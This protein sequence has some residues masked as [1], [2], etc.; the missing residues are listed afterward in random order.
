MDYPNA[1]A[2]LNLCSGSWALKLPFLQEA[3]GP[4]LRAIYVVRDPRAWVYLML[5]NSR[6]SLYSLKNIP[7][8]LSLIFRQDG[9]S[10]RCPSAFAP[11]FGPLWQ[12]VSRS[13]NSAVLL[14]AHLWRAHTAAVLRVSA[15]LPE[16][17]YLQLRFEDVVR[18]PLETAEQIHSFLGVP[19]S[20]AA[21][22]QLMFSTSTNLYSLQ[23]EGQVSASSMDRWRRRMPRRDVRLIEHTCGTLMR[24]LG[25]RRLSHG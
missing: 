1:R 18:Q 21:L 6:P 15:G 19:V 8:H 17:A 14:L 7:Q 10:E 11:E 13:E 9:A 5:Y 3:I 4:S 22:N 2:V 20:P 16:D 25:Y 12:L 23:Y 24:T